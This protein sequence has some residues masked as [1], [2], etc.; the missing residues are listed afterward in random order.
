[1]ICTWNIGIFSLS[2]IKR[3]SYSFKIR[4]A[5][6]NNKKFLFMLTQWKCEFLKH[7]LV[8]LIYMDKFL[9]HQKRL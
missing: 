6:Y 7:H 1:M 3:F 8:Y 4:L 2:K 9:K 5:S